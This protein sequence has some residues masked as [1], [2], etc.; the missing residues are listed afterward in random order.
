MMSVF[1]NCPAQATPGAGFTEG[2]DSAAPERSAGAECER[3]LRV[4]RPTRC[5]GREIGTPSTE[6]A[7]DGSLRWALPRRAYFSI[8]RLVLKVSGA[9]A[10]S[11]VPIESSPTAG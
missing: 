2:S 1:L 6:V 4:S 8:D 9:Q 5:R 10:R 7:P 11:S 3:W